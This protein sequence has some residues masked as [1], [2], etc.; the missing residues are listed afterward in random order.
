MPSTAAYTK[1]DSDGLGNSACTATSNRLAAISSGKSSKITGGISDLNQFASS[2]V[3][4][5]QN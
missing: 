1:L 3:A 5:V 4:A 2:V